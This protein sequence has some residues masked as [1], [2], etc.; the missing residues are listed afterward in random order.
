MNPRFIPAASVTG[1]L[2]WA[3]YWLLRTMPMAHT[4]MPRCASC[5]PQ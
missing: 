2:T 4:A 3:L 1:F 5:M